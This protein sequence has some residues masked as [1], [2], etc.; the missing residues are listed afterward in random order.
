[1]DKAEVDFV[2]FIG[3]KLLLTIKNGDLSLKI[4]TTPD[5]SV[6]KGDILEFSYLP[7]RV[8]IFDRDTE[9][10]ILVI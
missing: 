3:E 8:H 10:S 5:I 7:D 9:K 1:M 6:A 2:E 4:L